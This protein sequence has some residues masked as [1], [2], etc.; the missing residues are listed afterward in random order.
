MLHQLQMKKKKR[1]WMRDRGERGRE[2]E[3][4]EKHIETIEQKKNNRDKK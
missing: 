1:K 2:R 3:N 4:P